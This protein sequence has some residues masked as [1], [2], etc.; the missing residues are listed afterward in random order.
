MFTIS[1]KPTPIKAIVGLACTAGALIVSA[2]A[3]TAPA[4]AA[5]INSG[6]CPATTLSH[7]F[8][9]WGDSSS[10]ELV[11]GASF[12]GSL[13]GWSLAGGATRTTGS[14]PS[15][16]TGTVGQSSLRLPAGASAQSPPVCVDASYPTFRFFARNN[17]L[18]ASVAVQV[19][20][21]TLLGPVALPLGAAALSPTWRPTLP[22]LTGSLVGALLN[23]GTTQL[24]LR[25]TALLGT[26]QIDDVFVDPRGS[27]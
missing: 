25:F 1:R 8:A 18:L 14:E 10:Y 24:S 2:I 21:P 19:V 22:M 20:Y 4:G 13:A 16:V 15:G 7:P 12:E 17:S 27:R 11:P 9:A 23:G 3:V 5:L 26:S 6:T